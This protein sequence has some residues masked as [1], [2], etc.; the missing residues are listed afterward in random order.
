MD[1]SEVFE[2]LKRLQEVLIRK[3]EIEEEISN[4]PA[5]LKR[6][7]ALLER[8]KQEYIEQDEIFEQVR[9]GINE[10]KGELFQVELKRENAEKAMENVETQ[11]DYEAL[12]K[13][14]ND[15]KKKEEQMRFT[16]GTEE[17]RFEGINNDIKE[18]EKI[19]SENEAE[20][21]NMKNSLQDETSEMKQELKVLEQEKQKHSEGLDTETI[22][23]FERIIKSK[24]GNGIVPVRGGVCTG[25]NMILPAQFAND[26]QSESEIKYC[27]YC[28]R[29]LYY[30]PAELEVDEFSFDDSE[31]GWLD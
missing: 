5:V 23:K 18:K 14:I 6:H 25:C 22:F 31:M 11:R 8:L 9:K 16:L 27:P 28:S 29:V 21:E 4:A 19:I 15:S 1:M 26:I 20:I 7:E 2:R 3:N 10:L 12:E 13:T 30:E 24:L 17:E